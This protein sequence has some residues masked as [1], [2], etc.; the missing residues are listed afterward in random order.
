MGLRAPSHPVAQRL[1]QAFGGGIAAPSANR[2]GR[3]SPTTAQH[4]REELGDAVDLVLDGGAC[5]VGIESTIVDLS[6]GAPV[7][8]RP[9]RIGAAEI[10][11]VMRCAGLARHGCSR[12]AHRARSL[13]T[14]RP[15]YLWC[16]PSSSDLE[17][18]VREHATAPVAV[19]ARR[20]QPADSR[21]ALW[22]VAAADAQTYAHDLYAVAA[23]SRTLRLR[24]D[25]GGSAA[26]GAE[27]DGVRDRLTRAAAGSGNGPDG[28]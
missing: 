18:I 17:R 6:T 9:G 28:A 7:L 4:V 25:R 1:L 10:E 14:T 21:A 22:Q 5:E 16:S 15:R 23:L 26:R 2:F 13:R 20:A 24:A 3:I 12:R 11:A 19:L 8:L 27:W